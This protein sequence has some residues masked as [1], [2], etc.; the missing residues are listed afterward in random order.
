MKEE[1]QGKRESEVVK[2]KRRE[3]DESQLERKGEEMRSVS[4][5]KKNEGERDRESG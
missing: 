3:G 1:L 5:K 2:K 4:E